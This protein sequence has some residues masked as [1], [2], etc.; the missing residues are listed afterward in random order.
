VDA[1]G[2]DYLAD[3]VEDRVG[4]EPAER[5]HDLVG[6][7]LLARGVED[8]S[9]F[10]GQLVWL[11]VDRDVRPLVDA[12]WGD[13]G[14][15]A[16]HLLLGRGLRL[17]ERLGLPPLRAGLRFAGVRYLPVLAL[18][19]V[20]SLGA[21]LRACPFHLMTSVMAAYWRR[22]P[23]VLRQSTLLGTPAT[24]PVPGTRAQRPA[25]QS[26]FTGFHIRAGNCD[27]F[28]I[29]AGVFLDS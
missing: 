7:A 15:R 19:L 16:D 1:D 20:V 12:G 27:A 14:R 25:A 8:R 28:G 11:Q 2:A 29:A 26:A 4:G 5:V 10:G 21:V 17:V 6:R 13:A 18:H 24:G 9:A 23:D 3:G 22:T